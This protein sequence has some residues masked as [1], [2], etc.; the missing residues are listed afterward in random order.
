MKRMDRPDDKEPIVRLTD[1]SDRY[2]VYTI[3][4]G[5]AVDGTRGELDIDNTPSLL[6]ALED[7]LSQGNRALVIDMTPLTYIDSV[8]LAALVEIRQR[9]AGDST[10]PPRTVLVVAPPAGG[11]RRAF[12]I[13]RMN[14]VV[15]LR[16]TVAEAVAELAAG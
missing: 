10:H 7:E 13:M 8:G 11:V 15:N 16:P 4:G 3:Y 5:M 9:T 6:E 2:A 14:R 1:Q 12:D